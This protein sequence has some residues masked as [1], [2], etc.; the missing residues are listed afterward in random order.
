MDDT[1][2]SDSVTAPPAESPEPKRKRSNRGPHC[3]FCNDTSVVPVRLLI[4]A[5]V[6][7]SEDEMATLTPHVLR[8]VLHA[9]KNQAV[10]SELDNVEQTSTIDLDEIG[11]TFTA[12]FA[13]VTHGLSFAG[14]A[15]PEQAE[16]AWKRECPRLD[17]ALRDMKGGELQHQRVTTEEFARA[18]IDCPADR[19][20]VSP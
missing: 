9:S 10:Y 3:E 5:H 12:P 16:C 18:V 13:F 17:A 6:R 19:S 14:K 7:Y 20:C 8:F 4:M 11:D 2:Q 1:N 15:T